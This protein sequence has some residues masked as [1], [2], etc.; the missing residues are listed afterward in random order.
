MTLWPVEDR[1]RSPVRPAAYRP[2]QPARQRR[3]RR[4]ADRAQMQLA[5]CEFCRSR[6]RPPAL[7]PAG[8]RQRRDAALRA[9]CAHTRFRWLMPTVRPMP[10]R[11]F[12]R[13]LQSNPVGFA[14]EEALLP[15][16]ARSFVGFRLLTEYFAFPEKFLFVD[17]T[18]MEAK[19]LAL[20][21]QPHGDFRLSRPRPLPELERAIGSRRAGA[22]L[23]ADRQP[24]PAALRADLT[25]PYRD[26]IPHRA[27][28]A[29]PGGN[30][31]LA[32]RA[33]A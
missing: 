11:S 7:L 4:A 26:R 13:P 32:G 24:V 2:G 29:P 16:P 6:R 17:F 12:C 15:W 28:R 21:R 18:R 5:R 14:P 10:R 20:G 22:R 8:R 25:H 9:A 19:T 33:G 1:K 27:G 3:R 30:G 23:H 31:G